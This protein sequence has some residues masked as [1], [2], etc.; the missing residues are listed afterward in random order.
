MPI[1]LNR[2]K[3]DVD[4]R[5]P[6]TGAPEEETPLV[7][8]CW[9]LCDSGD[10][11]IAVETSAKEDMAV[12]DLF[13]S[14]VTSVLYPLAPIY[15]HDTRMLNAAAIKALTRIF[16]I[17]DAGKDGVLDDV[18]LNNFQT[19]CFSQ[20]NPLAERELKNVK[21]VIRM[22]VEDGLAR[23]SSEDGS[24]MVKLAGFCFLNQL[25]V[26]RAKPETIWTV[27]RAHGYADCL[28]LVPE[29]TAPELAVGLDSSTELS[30]DGLGFLSELF[31]R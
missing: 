20:S 6:V 8:E 25:F 18:E 2:N 31:D 29:Y 15:D 11:S 23:A 30:D 5:S 17:F 28:E 7:K 27:L 12:A 9:P 10:V 26:E 13:H 22:N 21:E 3:V 24:E 19:S 1:V 16:T 14:A 4:P